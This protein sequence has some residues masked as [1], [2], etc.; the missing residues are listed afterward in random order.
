M[1]DDVLLNM[2]R[3]DPERG[4]KKLIDTYAGL[5][6]TIVRNKLTASCFCPADIESCAADTFS[7]FYCDLDK[8]SPELGSIKSWLCVIAK[9]NAADRLRRFYK[10]ANILSS[11]S[12]EAAQYADDFS[13][14]GSFEDKALRA[15]LIN[16][17]KALGEPDREIMVRKYYLGQSA[18]EIGKIMGLSVSNVNTRASRAVSKLKSQ[19]G[20][21]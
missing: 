19:F 15:A 3:A 16:A 20:G 5:V 13:L 11:D 17:V 8:Y 14:E 21:D 1:R 7:E 6:Y 9:H 10:E 18:K 4:M 2:L 12:D